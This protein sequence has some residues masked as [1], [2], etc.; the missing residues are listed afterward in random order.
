M[1]AKAG[2]I[3]MSSFHRN[4]R[5]SVSGRRGFT[6]VELL[7][8]IAIIGVLIAL[9]LPAVQ[10]AREAARRSQ[11]VNCLKQ[12]GLALFNYESAKKAFPQGRMLPDFVLNGRVSSP[13][14]HY[15]VLGPNDRAGFV[16][17]H[18][19]LLPFMEEQAIY[20]MIDTTKMQTI[21]ENTIGNP[22]GPPPTPYA[23]PNFPAFAQAAGIFI[24]PSDPNTGIVISE[25]NYRYNFGGATPYAG[26]GG[27][28]V[29]LPTTGS[30]IGVGGGNGAFTIGK[31][32][33][34]KDFPD[35][36]SKTA[37]F[38]ERSKGSLNVV[39]SVP[40]THDDMIKCSG[41]SVSYSNTT[42]YNDPSS[43]TY[44]IYTPATT[45]LSPPASSFNFSATGRWDRQ[46]VSGSGGDPVGSGPTY[47]D[48]WPVGMYMAT[49]YNH[50]APPNFQGYDC[51]IT[52]ALPDTPTEH[53]MVS[54]RSYHT[55]IV[56]VC[57]GD[58]HVA[59]ISDN[60]D[61]NTWRALGTRNGAESVSDSY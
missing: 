59:T 44:K 42:N 40:P 52:S 31:A 18:V 54:A 15:P 1:E 47:T 11:C 25:N 14:T 10:A 28:A 50:V 30:Q 24:C 45:Y 5:S 38:S 9:L 39:A 46:A 35:G 7:V 32:L 36:L 57:F 53:A 17:V 41:G 61:L 27:G 51:G 58:G 37:F 16:S 2:G 19:W 29:A 48:G 8:V 3:F 43:D 26:F 55:G 22:G 34:V 12:I 4:V 20:A 56:N 23:N 13:G 6:L 49:M 60:I 21:M 33:R